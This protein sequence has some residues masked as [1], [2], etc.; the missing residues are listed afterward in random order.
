MRAVSLVFKEE[1]YKGHC[2]TM[3]LH[4]GERDYLFLQG[5]RPAELQATLPTSFNINCYRPYM[6]IQPHWE[7]QL[8]H[9]GLG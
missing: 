8:Q 6:Q 2:L 1:D 5:H 9:V 3:S 7:L 4:G